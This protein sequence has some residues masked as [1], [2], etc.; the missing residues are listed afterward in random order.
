MLGINRLLLLGLLGLLGLWRRRRWL[1]LLL[2]RS[3]LLGD[4]CQLGWLRGCCGGENSSLLSFGRVVCGGDQ[5]G[6][7]IRQGDDLLARAG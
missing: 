6:R 7:S 1:L 3:R 4:R 5:L 2:L